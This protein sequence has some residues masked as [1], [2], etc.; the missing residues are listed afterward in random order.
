MTSVRWWHPY[1]NM[2]IWN[3]KQRQEEKLKETYKVTSIL[4]FT[5]KINSKGD[6]PPQEKDYKKMKKKNK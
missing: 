5:K 4:S 2:G 1:G 6:P 3:K